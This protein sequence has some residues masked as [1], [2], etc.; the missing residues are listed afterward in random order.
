MFYDA[1]H[2]RLFTGGLD[3]LLKVYELPSYTVVHTEKFSSPVLSAGI[4][5]DRQKLLIGQSD[6]LSIRN[7]PDSEANVALNNQ[8]INRGSVRY[9]LNS[10]TTAAATPQHV[11]FIIN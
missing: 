3:N 4:S 11:C 9:F 6:N 10:V 8:R 1:S 2:N 7:R 5:P